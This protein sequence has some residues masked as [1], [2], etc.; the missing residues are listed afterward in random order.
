MQL[1]TFRRSSPRSDA[2][3]A[4]RKHTFY[5]CLRCSFFRF[6]ERLW[7]S[8][9]RRDLLGE[10]GDVLAEGVGGADV[11]RAAL[12]RRARGQL[13]L[14]ENQRQ[15]REQGMTGA[16]AGGEEEEEE[17]GGGGEKKGRSTTCGHS[18]S[19]CPDPFRSQTAAF[20]RMWS[21]SVAVFWLPPKCCDWPESKQPV[22]V[23]ADGSAKHNNM[24][25]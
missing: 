22:S 6:H 12:P 21:D 19:L 8:N 24:K 7:I 1:G 13:T 2:A 11:G 16:G 23:P 25:N 10:D 4:A 17:D 9:G 14:L 20:G 18:S 5:D 3:V 15:Q